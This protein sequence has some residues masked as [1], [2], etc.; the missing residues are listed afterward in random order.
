[1]HWPPR[2]RVRLP[3]SDDYT[4]LGQDELPGLWLPAVVGLVVFMALL[5]AATLM[6]RI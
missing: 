3:G 4:S 2:L 6:G 5:L 1:M